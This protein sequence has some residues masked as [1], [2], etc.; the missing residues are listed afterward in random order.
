MIKILTHDN[1]K[2]FQNLIIEAYQNEPLTF[3]HEFYDGDHLNLKD[4]R[5]LLHPDNHKRNVVFG[6]FDNQKLVGMIELDFIPHPSK[7]HKAFIQSLYVSPKYRGQSLSYQLMETLIKHAQSQHIEQLMLAI[8]SNNI[9]AKIF[10]NNLGFEFFAL[11]EAARK[12]N[13]QYIEEHWLI[14]NIGDSK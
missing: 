3:L 6:A 4:L 9:Q 13:N 11:E 2:D 1:A 14:Y 8:A 5:H 12:I 7:K 10:F